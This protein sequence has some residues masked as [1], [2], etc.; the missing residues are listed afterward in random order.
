ME[1]PGKL[2]D[3][4]GSHKSEN[5]NPQLDWAAIAPAVNDAM[6]NQ[7]KKKKRKAVL[8]WLSGSALI[9]IPLCYILLQLPVSEK[10]AATRY[11]RVYYCVR[12]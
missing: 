10:L 7:K 2:N 9:L 12:Y 6:T 5:S 4:L 1:G 3:L 11:R 8:W